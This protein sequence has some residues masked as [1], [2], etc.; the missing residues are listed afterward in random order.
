M[1]SPRLSLTRRQLRLGVLLCNRAIDQSEA[2]A[3][4]LRK[5]LDDAQD[6]Y[7][8]VREG[9]T[10]F[11]ER[12]YHPTMRRVIDAR[13]ALFAATRHNIELRDLRDRLQ[14]VLDK[15]QT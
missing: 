5:E 10:T 9:L 15:E 1:R 13:A 6:A 14:A 4:G 11:H 12:R 7:M 8:A 3:V 2:N